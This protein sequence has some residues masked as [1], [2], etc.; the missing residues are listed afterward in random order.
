[1][2]WNETKEKLRALVDSTACGARTKTTAFWSRFR[3]KANALFHSEKAPRP[4]L[5]PSR[6]AKNP[7]EEEDVRRELILDFS[8][9][10]QA[11]REPKNGAFLNSVDELC[12]A[13]IELSPAVLLKEAERKKKRVAD[14]PRRVIYGVCCVAFALSC[15]ALAENLLGKYRALEIYGR[16]EDEFFSAGFQFDVA[17][18][19]FTDLSDTADDGEVRRLSED[20]EAAAMGTM[21]EMMSRAET[22]EE[23]EVL[24]RKEYN[25]ELEKMRAGLASLAQ[26]N[27][28]IYGWI[29]IEGTAISYP[30]VQGDDNDYYLNH[31]Y[32]GD[33]LPEGSI[34][35][36]YRNNASI[37]KNYNTVFYGH[38]ITTGAM[39]HDVVKF[40]RSEYMNGVNITVYTQDGVFIYEPFSIYESRYDYNYF[41]TGFTGVED[42]V[43]FAEEMRDNSAMPVKEIEFGENDRILTLSTC[44]NGRTTQRYALHARLIQVIAD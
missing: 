28:D 27:P 7:M 32:T 24:E 40:F 36:D 21:E 16:L 9:P 12:E 17:S 19:A 15:A 25:E 1:M 38:N 5:R 2:N 31:A 14:L 13:D 30:L 8:G 22:G 6:R 23:P 18:A 39:F 20:A 35:V 33:Y 37:T 41:R 26:I 34:F 4:N 43:A 11:E 29:S 42:F 44:T 3:K 10:A